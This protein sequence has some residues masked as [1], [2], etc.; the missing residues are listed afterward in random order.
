MAM[1]LTCL[2][3]SVE[4]QQTLIDGDLMNVIGHLSTNNGGFIYSIETFGIYYPGDINVLGVKEGDIILN[5]IDITEHN[6]TINNNPFR[7]IVSED[8]KIHQLAG[9][10]NEVKFLLIILRP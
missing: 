10:M 1:A 3:V 4:L 9:A 7:G 6:I 2:T 8:D 5:V